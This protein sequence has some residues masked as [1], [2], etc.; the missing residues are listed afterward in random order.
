MSEPNLTPTPDAPEGWPY[1]ESQVRHRLGLGR[2]EMRALRRAHLAPF[3]DFTLYKKRVYLSAAAVTR[4]LGMA[5]AKLKKSCG[6]AMAGDGGGVKS[7]LAKKAAPAV[8]PLRVV[9]ADLRNRHLI[10][11][12][13]AGEDP[14]RPQTTVRVRVRSAENFTRRMELPAVLAEGHRDLYDLARPLPRK[15]GK[16]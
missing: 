15:R 11:C 4:L 8:V 13:P 6:S 1:E 14:D 9:R 16:W 3:T 2:D 5:D 7:E 10:L 12:C